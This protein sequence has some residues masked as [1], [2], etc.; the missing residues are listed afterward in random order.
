MGSCYVSIPLIGILCRRTTEKIKSV[1][2]ETQ[3]IGLKN[4]VYAALKDKSYLCL[5]AGF[6]TC[7]FHVAFLVTHLPGEVAYT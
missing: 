3:D 4:Q 7:G 5:H 1:A 2:E 6:F